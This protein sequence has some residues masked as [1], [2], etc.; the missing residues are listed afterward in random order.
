MHRET[1][2]IPDL[3]P[4][5]RITRISV[6]SRDSDRNIDTTLDQP[7][8]TISMPKPVLVNWHGSVFV[9]TG[10]HGSDALL[11]ARM[12]SDLGI[13]VIDAD[14]HKASEHLFP[15][16]V[17]DVKDALNYIATQP[18]L[19]DPRNVAVSAFSADG[20]L[21]LIQAVAAVY[22]ATDKNIPNE[23]LSVPKPIN[24]MAPRMRNFLDGCYLP[25]TQSRT[26]PLVSPAYA[27]LHA[28]PGTVVVFTAEGDELST[29]AGVFARKVKVRERDVV[30]KCFEDMWHGFDKGAKAGTEAAECRNEAYSIIAERLK[31]VL[32]G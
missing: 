22:P 9:F 23:G 30:Y 11:C 4:N 16:A 13:Y 3:Y 21:A 31:V 29:E 25:E 18:K 19:F 2:R 20:T 1:A 27:L 32:L 5:L 26:D 10:I 6:P 7:P 12:V 28:F 17:H 24:L 14:Y 8:S 15:A